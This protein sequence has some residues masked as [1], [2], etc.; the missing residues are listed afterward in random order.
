MALTP[1]ALKIS[2]YALIII[3]PV[4]GI[5]FL[6]HRRSYVN[7]LK[8]V[9]IEK[10][11]IGEIETAVIPATFNTV[12]PTNVRARNIFYNRLMKCGSRSLFMTILR[13][14]T[15]NNISVAASTVYH[16]EHP[17]EN[18]VLEEIKKIV[19]LKPPTIYNRHIHYVDFEKRGFPQPIYIN[20]IRD[21]VSRYQSHYNYFTYGDMELGGANAQRK[22]GNISRCILQGE[23][24]CRKPEL[25]RYYTDYF[26]GFDP[27]CQGP[28]PAKR[29][30]MAKKHISEKYLAIGTTEDFENTLK[31][32][33]AMM[34]EYF[35]GAPKAW[36]GIRKFA[37]AR[38]K[39][40]TREDGKMTESA[41]NKLRYEV[42]ADD[43]EVYEHALKKYA[44]LKRQYGID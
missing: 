37:K 44:E 36:R 19:G 22:K 35:R 10:Q 24:F 41:F 27:I 4:L 30:K 13:I 11:T 34:P 21:P 6:I 40:F 2:L 32:L 26:C 17:A 7:N 31:L 8:R 9:A 33:E 16:E 3:I 43:Y 42:L 25:G 23:R 39:S 29:V 14:A 28:S 18:Q 38:T 1:K 20:L 15:A 12:V 5:Q